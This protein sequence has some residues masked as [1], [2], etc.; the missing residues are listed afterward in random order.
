MLTISI[1]PNLKRMDDCINIFYSLKIN[2]GQMSNNPQGNRNSHY[3]FPNQKT[4]TQTK[5]QMARWF[6]H[7]ILPYFQRRMNDSTS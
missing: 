1:Q 2:Q 5:S 4:N 7:R 3:K 6:D